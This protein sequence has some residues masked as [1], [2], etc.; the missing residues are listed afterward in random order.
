MVQDKNSEKRYE[1]NQ[2]ILKT[3]QDMEELLTQNRQLKALF[4]RTEETFSREFQKLLAIDENLKQRGSFSARWDL[5]EH[6]AMRQGFI[7]SVAQY[8]ENL[9]QAFRRENA[10]LDERREKLQQERDA[11]SWD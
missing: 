4:E 11:L 8:E 9:A 10:S 2:Q 1:Y 3:E 5:E 7:Q 6:Q